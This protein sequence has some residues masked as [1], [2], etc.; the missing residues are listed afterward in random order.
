MKD[1]HKFVE[2][3]NLISTKPSCSS[4]QAP[5]KRI[6]GHQVRQHFKKATGEKLKEKVG[7]QKWQGRLLWTRWEDNQLNKHGCFTWLNGW[8]YT[9]T[10][11][12]AGIMELY[13]L[14]T[15]V[16]STYKTGTSGQINIV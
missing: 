9:L 1:A 3:L 8:A 4:F 12:V 14:P 5:E 15:R 2:E 16:Y 7:D 13:F 6:G 10:H 11:A